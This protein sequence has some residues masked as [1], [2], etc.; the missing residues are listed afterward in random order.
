MPGE[1]RYIMRGLACACA[2]G[3]VAILAA[4]FA[5]AARINVNWDEFYFLTHVHALLRGE[6]DLLL[7]GAYT[8][9]FRWIAWTG[10]DEM[11]QI[12]RL[13]HAMCVLLAISAALTYAFARLW[14][15]RVGALLAVLAFLTSW[16]V[17]RHGASFRA[18]SILLP[19][20]LAAFYFALRGG[21]NVRRD[22]VVAG[23]FLGLAFVVTVKA[24]LLLPAL[25]LMAWLPGARR[26]GASLDSLPGATWQAGF[27]FAAAAAVSFAALLLHGTQIVAASEP[28]GE[29]ASRSLVSAILD[30]PFA[31]RRDIFV[32]LVGEDAIYWIAVLA[33][34]L[35]AIRQRAFGL[36]A[37]ALCFAPVLFYR[38]AFQ[39]YFPVMM[40]PASVLVAVAADRLL[41]VRDAR[42]RVL[43]LA[44]MAV[45]CLGLVRGGW[46]GVAALRFDEQASERALVAAVHRVFP[47][48]VPYLDH[49]GMIAS[50]PKVNFF[51][52]GWGVER[53]LRGGEDFMPA[54]LQGR[55][56][57]LL[58][59][60]HSVLSP[61]ALPYRQL[62]PKDRELIESRYVRYWGR[63]G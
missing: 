11:D 50:Y 46:I 12:L 38:N 6:L 27:M 57:P 32:R 20:T 5:L 3:S 42:G 7:Q 13:R 41:E 18:D 40:A 33:G 28:A 15:S 22:A 52:S 45:A 24:V 14:C 39:Y 60:N 49:G 37:A 61:G 51:M 54:A 4:K 17:L 58:L 29:F 36:A 2:A 16:P 59:V 55:C 53:Y 21:S 26:L 62:R 63:S 8:H 44:A 1:A 56:P 48:P 30:V 19:L 9:A 34:F 35:V 10:G 25:V 47:Q 31:P 43:A 23:V